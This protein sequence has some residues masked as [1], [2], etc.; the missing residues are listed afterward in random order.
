MKEASQMI[1]SMAKA[2]TLN[3]TVNGMRVTG[4]TESNMV[5]ANIFSRTEAV[6]PASG[7]TASV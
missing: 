5:R 7:R 6:R 3:P 2:Y 4:I 1:K